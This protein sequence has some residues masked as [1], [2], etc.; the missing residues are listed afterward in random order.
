[1]KRSLALIPWFASEYFADEVDVDAV[2]VGGVAQDEVSVGK[3]CADE[4]KREEPMIRA[5]I[6]GILTSK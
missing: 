2:L 6:P 4:T 1:M 3:L 5:E